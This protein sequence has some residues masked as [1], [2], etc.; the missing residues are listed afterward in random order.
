MVKDRDD[1]TS[2][3]ARLTLRHT[4]MPKVP[5]D[6]AGPSYFGGLD[7]QLVICAGKGVHFQLHPTVGQFLTFCQAGDIHIWDR[8][9]AVLLHHIRAQEV[10]GDLTCIAWNPAAE[11][12][13]MFGTGSHDGAVRIWSSPA[14]GTSAQDEHHQSR[15]THG[16]APDID[17]S[18]P[19]DLDIEY[20]RTD[21]PI[22]HLE[23]DAQQNYGPE[24]EGGS[25][26]RTVAFA[27]F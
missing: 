21:S 20:H 4:F 24:N 7:D 12:P 13:F 26:E 8:V 10:G 5:V 19:S 16:K 27:A 17:I 6:F 23:S 2:Q 15:Q 1:N 9:S 11:D 3:H 18:L 14:P 25:R 22:Q